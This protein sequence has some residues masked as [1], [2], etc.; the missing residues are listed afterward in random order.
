V[1]KF[2]AELHAAGFDLVHSNTPFV[3]YSWS[4]YPKRNHPGPEEY[5]KKMTS[6]KWFDF[7]EDADSAARIRKS[8]TEFKKPKQCSNRDE[9]AK[10]V[11][12][13]H[14][15]AEGG[16]HHVCFL[17]TDSP[18][19]E[20]R[21]LEVSERFTAG[22]GKVEPIDFGLDLDGRKYKLSVADVSLDQ[23]EKI[24]ANPSQSVPKDWTIDR[25]LI[26]DRRELLQ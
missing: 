25:M 21:L 8:L 3:A 26:W 24:K 15:G 13:R 23:L 7:L 4:D 17:P 22:V 2:P 1:F 6:D 16:I 19:D 20:I 14:M 18:A 9:V 5:A 11:A 10:W 12:Q